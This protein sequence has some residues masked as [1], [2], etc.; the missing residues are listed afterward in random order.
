MTSILRTILSNVAGETVAIVNW[1][2]PASLP[3]TL[4][5]PPASKKMFSSPAE[6][7]RKL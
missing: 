4:A 1:L 2:N 6:S 5:C 7:T 3:T